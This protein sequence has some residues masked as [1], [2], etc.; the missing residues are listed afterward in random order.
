M[1]F[2]WDISPNFPKNTVYFHFGFTQ[3]TTVVLA[4]EFN[5]EKS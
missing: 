3:Q 4:G 1:S 5:G 2:I